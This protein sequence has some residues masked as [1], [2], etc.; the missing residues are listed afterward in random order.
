MFLALVMRDLVDC[1][2]LPLSLCPALSKNPTTSDA[3][4][5][6]YIYRPLKKDNARVSRTFFEVQS[7]RGRVH[8]SNVEM[9]T[10]CTDHI[11][12]LPR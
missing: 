6:G 8:R 12:L 10:L 5:E 3:S 2:M 9:G 1:S 4:E 7:Q 11:S